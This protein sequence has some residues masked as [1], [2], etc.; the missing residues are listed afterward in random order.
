MKRKK[1]PPKGDGRHGVGKTA[2]MR[3][4]SKGRGKTG[5]PAGRKDKPGKNMSPQSGGAIGKKRG[6]A[7][8]FNKDSRV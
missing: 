2:G 3:K 1:A 8:G 4:S 6:K 5:S 7:L